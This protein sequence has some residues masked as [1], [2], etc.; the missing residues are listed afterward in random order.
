MVIIFRQVFYNIFNIMMVIDLSNLKLVVG[1]A[2]VMPQRP[3]K[4]GKTDGGDFLR[5][6]LGFLQDAV[7]AMK[8][9]GDFDHRNGNVIAKQGGGTAPTN[10]D[11]GTGL[12]H[13]IG[14]IE[15][16]RITKLIDG[17]FQFALNKDI[18]YSLGN[19]AGN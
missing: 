17:D 15:D 8:I 5:F 14:F 2:L 1:H 4:L 18:D 16:I 11:S 12:D 3:A 7:Y 19:S 13:F 10:N 9:M 6:I